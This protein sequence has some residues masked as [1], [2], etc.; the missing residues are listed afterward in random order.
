MRRFENLSLRTRLLCGFGVVVLL[1]GVVAFAAVQGADATRTAGQQAQRLQAVA[2]ATQEIRYYNADVSGWQYAVAYEAENA[3]AP[4]PDDSANRAGQLADKKQLDRTLATFPVADATPAERKLVASMNRDWAEFWRLDS[5][6]FALYQA[7][8][9]AA[10]IESHHAAASELLY[11]PLMKTYERLLVSTDELGKSVEKRVAAVNASSAATASSSIRTVIIVA[12]IAALVAIAA[13]LV[14]TRTVVRPVATLVARLRSLDEQD[15]GSLRAGLSAMAGG[16]LTVEAVSVTREIDDVGDD[17]I[18]AASKTTNSLIAKTAASLNDYNRTRGALRS[19]VG[20]VLETAG[21][22]STS[23]Q[24]M[25]STSEEA[26]RA[27]GEIAQA[28]SDVAQGAERQV[29]SV[30]AAKAATEEVGSA[31]QASA[32]SAKETAVAADEARRFAR[33]GEHA[34]DQATNA[35]R[36]VR[37][38]STQ[39]TQAMHQLASKNEQIGGI[40]AT[41][42][43]IAGQTNLLALNAAIEAARAGE[44]GRGFAVVAEEVRKLAEESQ[45]AA[46]AIASLVEDIQAETTQ[47]VTVVEE[48]AVRSEEGAATV[49]QAREAFARIG[50]SVEDMTGR[51]EAIAAAVE[52]IAA[53][54]QKVGLDMT[55]VAAIAEESSAS[56]E[57]VSASTQE[58]SASTQE[59]ASSA[60]SLARSA[61]HLN[62]LVGQFSL[63]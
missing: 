4:V 17:E 38:S 11:G 49:D 43:G 58:T 36:H 9:D 51:V 24:E 63:S 60:A 44:Q 34:V 35:M 37:D 14:L 55:D 25:A 56:S 10:T 33:E 48:G 19:L 52:Q 6:L 59:I 32:R 57:E 20:E 47:A 5:R 45:E 41:I 40:V 23:S 27:V 39:V 46:A 13:A 1:L 16:D 7:P 62:E 53:A 26:G 8:G 61:E 29:R 28:V 31:T 3:A 15:M 22:L 54:A 12:V 42:T 21:S 2:D 18:G 50:A 30:E